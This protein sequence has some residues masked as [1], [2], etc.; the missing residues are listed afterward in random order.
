M[1]KFVNIDSRRRP[2][3]VHI[4]FQMILADDDTAGKPDSHDEGFW[5]SQDES[6]PGYVLPEN[7]ET[8][9]RK[10]KARMAA[11]KRGAWGYVGVICRA[12]IMLPI[13]GASFRMMTMD[14]AGIWGIES[15]AGDYLQTVFEE[16][17]AGLLDEL[18]NLGNAIMSDDYISES[19]S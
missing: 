15:D 5:P 7:F 16:E 2:Q 12:T 14:S 6:A 1:S 13:G 17:K 18:R 11:F 4:S 9:M 8:E 3:K 19:E 10:A